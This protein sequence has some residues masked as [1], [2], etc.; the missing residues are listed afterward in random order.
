MEKT[1]K[2]SVQ[3][4]SSDMKANGSYDELELGEYGSDDML[5]IF[6]LYS[7]V[8]EIFPENNEDLCPASLYVAC[9]GK[10]YSFYLDNGLIAD[11]DSD[12]KLSPEEALKFV[13]GQ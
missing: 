3:G 7:S 4:L 2:V 10:N 6:I 5:G 11:V 1:F 13:S 9:E 12:A 8:V